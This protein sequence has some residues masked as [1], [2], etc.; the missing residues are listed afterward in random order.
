MTD[1]QIAMIGSLVR[2]LILAAGLGGMFTGDQLTQFAGAVA[3]IVSIGWGLW[4]KKSAAED[5]HATVVKAV[6]AV[7]SGTE[8][9]AVIAASKAGTL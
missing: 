7:A 3:M 4:Q 6:Q 8:P 5:K 2:A 9:H 1:V